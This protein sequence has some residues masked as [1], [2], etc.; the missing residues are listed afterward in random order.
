M[1][2]D[3]DNQATPPNMLGNRLFEMVYHRLKGIAGKQLKNKSNDSL[4]TTALVHELYVKMSSNSELQFGSQNQFFDY[5]AKSMRHI[6]IDRARAKLRNK[7]GGK[8]LQQVE[9]GEDTTSLGIVTAER[10]FEIDSALN[11]L[12]QQ[13][14][15]AARIVE[16]HFFAG[17]S[18]EE[19]A[20]CM[21]ISTRT[22]NREWRFA[23]A[24]LHGGAL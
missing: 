11:I 3:S 6:M 19:V 18:L 14:P 13:A 9:L 16:L 10:A 15:R 2:N 1:K 17:L 20:E 8:E 23:R 5:A 12:E 4:N 24:F 7:R 21:N 22:V